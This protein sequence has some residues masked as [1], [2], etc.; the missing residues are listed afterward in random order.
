MGVQDQQ[1]LQDHKDQEERGAQ[2]E[3]L[4]LVVLREL[5]ENQV[6]LVSLVPQ[7]LLDIH[8]TQDLMA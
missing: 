3:N 2:K 8:P 1:D 6:F 5:M 7:G 4:V